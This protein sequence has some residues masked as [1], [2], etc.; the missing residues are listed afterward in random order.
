MN[1][2]SVIYNNGYKYLHYNKT[3]TDYNNEIAVISSELILTYN[4]K[5]KRKIKLCTKIIAKFVINNLIVVITFDAIYVYAQNLNLVKSITKINTNNQNFLINNLCF[6]DYSEKKNCL[7]F[8]SGPLI[9]PNNCAIEIN[10]INNKAKKLRFGKKTYIKNNFK[11]KTSLNLI[12]TSH[13]GA[14]YQVI[15]EKLQYLDFY[16]LKIR[17]KLENNI[18]FHWI[19]DNLVFTFFND[20]LKINQKIIKYEENE[21]LY[22]IYEIGY[23]RKAKQIEL[24]NWLNKPVFFSIL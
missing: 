5:I 20:K 10:I 7:Y 14:K 4:D 18:Y 23:N 2:P 13:L 19:E 15:N 6:C 9:I 11:Y 21:N 8:A 1:F 3:Q 17:F 16:N 24:I 22:N 12:N